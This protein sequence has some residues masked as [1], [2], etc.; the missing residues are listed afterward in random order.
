MVRWCWVIVGG[1]LGVVCERWGSSVCGTH[2]SLWGAD[3]H[4]GQL[5]FVGA[6]RCV[7]A[8][9]LYVGVGLSFVGA[10]LS[11][12]GT[13]LSFVGGMPCSCVVYVLHG[14]GWMFGG[15]GARLSFVGTL[16]PWCV[17]SCVVWSSL[18]RMDGTEIT[19]TYLQTTTTNDESIIL[20]RL[21]ATSL[22]VTWKLEAPIPL[23]GLVTWR[24][25]VLVAEVAGMGDRCEW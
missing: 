25:K 3:V 13:R 10:R 20:C 12:V 24:C 6:E 7:G 2:R 4:G 5:W 19:D 23:I 1:H 9:S 16:V 8:G 15:M 11:F 14:W 17:M 21:V 18:A 22:S